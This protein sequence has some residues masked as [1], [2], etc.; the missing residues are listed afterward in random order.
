M[1]SAK[2]ED[3]GTPRTTTL[4]TILQEDE[5]NLTDRHSEL[6]TRSCS[7]GIESTTSDDSTKT[8]PKL[9]VFYFIVHLIPTTSHKQQ[10]KSRIFNPFFRHCTRHKL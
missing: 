10:Q 1:K 3:L 5:A 8:L 4:T 2:E 6:T 9:F 7:D